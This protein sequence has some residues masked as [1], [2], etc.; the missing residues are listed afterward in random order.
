[1]R[2]IS[3]ILTG[4]VLCAVIAF[5]GTRRR[6]HEGQHQDLHDAPRTT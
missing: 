5:S 1:M 6:R 4:A 3:L 2:R